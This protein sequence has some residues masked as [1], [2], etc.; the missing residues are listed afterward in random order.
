VVAEFGPGGVGADFDAFDLGGPVLGEEDVVDVVEAILGVAEGADRKKRR[1]RE[2][3]L[4]AGR[5][6]RRSERE[7]KSVGLLRSK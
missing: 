4:C 5:H 6:V 7:R 3:S 1:G 2:I